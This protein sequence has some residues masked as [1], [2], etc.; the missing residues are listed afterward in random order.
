MFL[1]WQH[2]T[3]SAILQDI[4]EKQEKLLKFEI[5]NSEDAGK[6]VLFCFVF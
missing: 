5:G 1:I 4:E 6:Y 2:Q 3:I